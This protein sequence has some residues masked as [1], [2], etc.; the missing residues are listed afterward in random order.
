MEASHQ[1]LLQET[2]SEFFSKMGFQAA[3]E[4]TVEEKSETI[5]CMAR[6][7]GDQS[8]LIGQYGANLAAIQHII[9]VLVRKKNGAPLNI[10]VDVNGY[11]S[12]KRS[13]IEK[14]AERAANEALE[15]NVSVALRPMLPYERKLVHSF[16][17]ENTRVTTESVG[18]GEERKIMVRPVIEAEA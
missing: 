12:E 14:E 10:I 6:V 1:K 15:S 13:L 7:E 4:T 9:R 3:V 8:F 18:K 11:F 2:V 5:L 17:A 16:L